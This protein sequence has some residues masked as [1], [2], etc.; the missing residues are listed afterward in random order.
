[1]DFDKFIIWFALIIGFS[2]LLAHTY[3]IFDAASHTGVVFPKW[4][5]QVDYNFYGEGPIEI[6]MLPFATL[7]SGYGIYLYSREL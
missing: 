2:G 6:V 5:T 4:V 3:L 7:V 1:M